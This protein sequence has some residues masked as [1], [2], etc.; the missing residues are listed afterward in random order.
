MENKPQPRVHFIGSF[1]FWDQARTGRQAACGRGFFSAAPHRNRDPSPTKPPVPLKQTRPFFRLCS[2]ICARLLFYAPHRY[3]SVRRRGSRSAAIQQQKKKPFRH[4]KTT[5][6]LDGC[7][8]VG[9]LLLSRAVTSQ[10]SSARASLTS[11]FGMGTGGPSPSST[12]TPKSSNF[13]LYSLFPL[14]PGL[15]LGNP[16]VTRAGIEPTFAA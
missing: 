5:I 2:S 14:A 7:L 10:V 4:K 8:N 11:V 3:F 12:P 9:I 1:P 13:V 16:L 6:L 15:L